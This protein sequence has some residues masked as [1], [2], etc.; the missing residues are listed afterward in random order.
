[1]SQPLKGGEPILTEEKNNK[2]VALPKWNWGA[3]G[4]TWIWGMKNNVPL[5][6]LG[7]IPGINLVISVIGGLYGYQWLWEKGSYQTI[8]EMK[9]GEKLWNVLGIVNAIWYI[10]L[11]S[12]LILAIFFLLAFIV[13]VSN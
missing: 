2:Q 6:L 12:L 13:A 11:F 5:M 10:M 1:M 8:E 3:F 7:A 9:Q 4:L